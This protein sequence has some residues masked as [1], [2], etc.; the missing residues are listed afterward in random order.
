MK[1]IFTS[2]FF[3]LCAN[4]ILA[5][6]VTIPDPNFKTA[7]LTHDPVIDTNSDGEIQVSEAEVITY[8]INVG[9]KSI[10]DMT[11]IEAFVNLKDLNCQ[12]N[13]ITHLNITNLTQLERLNAWN[14]QFESLDLSTN[15]MLTYVELNDN[16]LT[17]LDVSQNTQLSY[18]SI[19]YNQLTEIDLST[20]TQL[21]IFSN[22]SNN[23]VS[24]DL[25]NSP[26]LTFLGIQFCSTLRLINIQNGNN[27]NLD[28][29]LSDL[30]ALECVIIDPDFVESP[31]ETWEYPEGTTFTSKCALSTSDLQLTELTLYPNPVKNEFFIQSDE[32]VECVEIYTLSGEKIHSQ[33]NS[34]IHSVKVSHLS[35][36]VYLTRIKTVT[37]KVFT[38]KIIIQ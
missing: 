32:K 16:N 20:L 12:E 37:G 30:P 22:V 13:L 34:N 21:T 9:N 17:S 31:P 23:L 7:L 27:E 10:S 36:G 38:Q 6:N 33:K 15:T 24:I 14:N 11:G 35:K 3:I 4:L 29:Y 26:L 1:T 8:S 18:L 25:S 5:Q 28:I 19:S 2:F